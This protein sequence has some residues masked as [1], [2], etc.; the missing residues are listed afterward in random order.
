MF[1]LSENSSILY[2]IGRHS[3]SNCL[4]LHHPCN[5]QN[6]KSPFLK[7]CHRLHIN[8]PSP[9]PIHL[10]FTKIINATH[11]NF[12]PF[13]SIYINPYIINLSLFFQTSTTLILFTLSSLF[14]KWL[15]PPF[16]PLPR[17]ILMRSHHIPLPLLFT[18]L[19]LKSQNPPQLLKSRYLT[20]SLGTS[21]I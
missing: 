14:Q 21:F 2:E 16:P 7:S 12:Q 10:P 17:M 18:S 8:V 19:M 6:L 1:Y 20:L 15:L 9:F 13:S 3:C 5:R 4:N 11:F